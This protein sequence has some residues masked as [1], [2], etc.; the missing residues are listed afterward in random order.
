ME[1]DKN[2]LPDNLCKSQWCVKP[3]RG[4]AIHIKLEKGDLAVN[5]CLEGTSEGTLERQ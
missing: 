4:L 5:L 1:E 3:K 2:T